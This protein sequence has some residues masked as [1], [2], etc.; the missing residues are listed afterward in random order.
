MRKT[1]LLVL[2][3]FLASAASAQEESKTVIAGDS[4][5]YKYTPVESVTAP[6][7]VAG[8][9]E[10]MEA[11]PADTVRKESG[12]KRFWKRMGQ[13]SV[14][15]TYTKKIDFSIVGGP[16]YSKSTSVGIGILAAGLYRLDR[17][18]KTLPPSNISLFGSIS[19]KGLYQIGIEGTNIFKGDRHRLNYLAYFMSMPKGFWGLGYNGG[20][21]DCWIMNRDDSAPINATAYSAK[22][23]QVTVKYLYKVYR[24]VFLGVNLDFNHS[25]AYGN[26]G[27]MTELQ[28]MLDVSALYGHAMN[29]G[30]KFTTTGIGFQFEYDSRDI[31]SNAYKGMFFSLLTTI[32]P[33]FLGNLNRTLWNTKVQF[34]IY[35]KVWKDCIMAVDLYGEF[36]SK[37]TPW[38]YYAELGGMY[39]MRGY[40]RGRFTDLNVIMAQVELRQKIWK[41]LGATAWVGC[42]NSFH[43]FDTFRWDETL[44]NYGVGLRWEFK[45]RMNIRL[46]Y[47]FGKKIENKRT[48]S[49]IFSIS[50]A[51]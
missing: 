5:S 18:D 36:C 39:R 41:R 28:R 21:G 37:S 32:R 29:L 7:T 27:Q 31:L 45:A 13:N 16:Y 47:G 8:T 49:F 34:D 24:H 48:Q 12:W 19:V 40:Y 33:G 9:A 38:M 26:A 35:Q 25:Y 14:D 6:G 50:E 3:V 30:T 20:I 44:P 17:S 4:V 22:K 2:S 46:D 51:F 15:K 1:L 42:G 10:A 11:A 43:Q 23:Y